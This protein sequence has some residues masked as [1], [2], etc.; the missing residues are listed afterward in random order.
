MFPTVDLSEL[1]A[2]AAIGDERAWNRIVVTYLPL[3]RHITRRYRLSDREAEDVSQTVW[4]RLVERIDTIREPRA[5]PG[6]IVTT[7]KNESLRVLRVRRNAGDPVDPASHGAF[8]LGF[9]AVGVDDTLLRVELQAAVRDGL[10]ELTPTQ[11]RLLQLLVAD[12]PHSYEE[13]GAMMDMPIGSIGPT[14]ARALAKL[15]ATEAMQRL[16][17]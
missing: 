17:Q 3:V 10:A 4:L 14:R 9:D 5:L 15:R 12:P 11:S 7:T 13:I 6:W 8:E 16:L 1:V 2:A